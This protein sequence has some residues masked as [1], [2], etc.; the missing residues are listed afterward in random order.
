VRVLG[1]FANAAGY[2]R[3][4]ASACL[5]VL[6]A[7][8][9]CGP[10]NSN[11]GC[12]DHLLPGDLVIT[13][14]FA[15]FKAPAGG[16]SA[17]DGKEWFEIYN[18]SNRPLE[19]EGLAVVHGPPDNS[20]AKQHVVADVTIDSGQYFTL[21]NAPPNLRPAYVDYGYGA[22]LGSLVNTDDGKLL[23][24]CGSDEID[25]AIYDSVKQG[26]SRELTAA[27]PPDYTLNDDQANWCEGD[28]TEFDAGN[29]GTPG[30]DSDCQP[31]VQG[32]CLDHGSMRATV[33]PTPGDLVITE[34]MPSPSQVDDTVG[35][36]FE[37]RVLHDV[38]L[39]GVGL[40]R[41]GDSSKPDVITASDCIHVIAGQ[42]IVFAKS[43][44]VAV[45]GGIPADEIVGTFKFSI[46]GGSASPGDV[47]ILSGGA[48]VDA[49]TWTR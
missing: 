26:H 10:S 27:Q 3:D 39:N 22:D 5:L 12:K 44:D 9:G 24:R 37:A 6:A 32:Q 35:E 8:T 40:D 14:V 4:L 25:G 49:I 18:A 28:A 2:V 31:V 48:V 1:Y 38:D 43:N 16:T 21:G 29:F 33:A 7:V 15:D 19:L 41:A 20:S 46:V 34:V 42:D 23:L 13:E 11:T 47:Q 30:Q 45:N 36:W 17:D